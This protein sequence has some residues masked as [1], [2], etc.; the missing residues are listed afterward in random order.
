MEIE[1]VEGNLIMDKGAVSAAQPGGIIHVS[2]ATDAVE[3]H[4]ASAGYHD[5]FGQ[6]L[7]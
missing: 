2:G 6:L 5:I 4:P 7:H 3:F 1:N